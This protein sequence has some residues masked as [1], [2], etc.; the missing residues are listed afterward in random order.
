LC[1][2]L[3]SHRL[4]RTGSLHH[5]HVPE[6]ICSKQNNTPTLSIPN[7]VVLHGTA[8]GPDRMAQTS[9]YALRLTQDL[10]ESSLRRK[11]AGT[12]ILPLRHDSLFHRDLFHCDGFSVM[13]QNGLP[14]GTTTPVRALRRFA[15]AGHTSCHTSR[16]LL[17]G[18]CM[19]QYE[20]QRGTWC[21]VPARAAWFLPERLVL[22]SR[23]GQRPIGFI[24]PFTCARL[25]R[26]A[27]FFAAMG[28]HLR[29]APGTV[30]PMRRFS[31]RS[32]GQERRHDETTSFVL[33]EHGG[34]RCGERC[35]CSKRARSATRRRNRR[36]RG[37]IRSARSGRSAG[38]ARDHGE[39]SW[40]VRH[41]RRGAAI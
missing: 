37:A 26:G 32:G 14:V 38:A 13:A 33:H 2:N 30:R 1:E 22:R 17:A 23:G 11:A 3:S 41:G 25:G 7:N 16:C 10:G 29:G 20:N 39:G 31:D 40:R 18:H 34:D 6:K 12:P 27:F 8:T 21:M 35:A 36:T 15:S 5:S 4:S 19:L 28:L 9:G 24:R